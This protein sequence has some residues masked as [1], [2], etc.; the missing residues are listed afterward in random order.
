MRLGGEGTLPALRP[1]DRPPAWH[2]PGP[3]MAPRGCQW[4]PEI[5]GA[6]CLPPGPPDGLLTSTAVADKARAPSVFRFVRNKHVSA[7]QAL[8]HLLF[9]SCCHV[10]EVSPSR[11]RAVRVR[12]AEDLPELTPPLPRWWALGWRP[13]AA[14]EPRAAR[15][16]AAGW[17]RRLPSPHTTARLP[18]VLPNRLPQGCTCKPT[19]YRQA[20]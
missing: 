2:Q 7:L 3:E 6:K 1:K 9:V 10:V 13:G 17:D 20:F 19:G 11:R 5:N 12:L 16:L 4:D 15:T 18:E 8:L 14:S